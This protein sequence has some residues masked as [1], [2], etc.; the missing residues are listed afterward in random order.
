MLDVRY[1][2]ILDIVTTV[3]S[4]VRRNDGCLFAFVHVPV[5]CSCSFICLYP[6]I[7]QALLVII[8]QKCHCPNIS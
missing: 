3:F 6:L 8:Y 4:V 7:I 1:L 5:C 2:G